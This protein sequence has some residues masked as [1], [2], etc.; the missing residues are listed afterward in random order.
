MTKKKRFAAVVDFYIY[1]D[2]END[3]LIEVTE[4]TEYL[5]EKYD[6]EANLVTMQEAEFGQIPTKQE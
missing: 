3:A 5:K 6:N 2:T 4:I 1:A